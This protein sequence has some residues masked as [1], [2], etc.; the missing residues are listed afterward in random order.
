MDTYV[1][2]VGLQE[3]QDDLR[4]FTDSLKDVSDLWLK[5]VGPIRAGFKERMDSKGGTDRWPRWARSTVFNYSG[6]GM[7]GALLKSSGPGGQR[8]YNSLVS[9]G[10]DS[11]LNIGKTKMQIGTKREH[12]VE[13]NDGVDKRERGGFGP[14]KARM[15]RFYDKDW[16]GNDKPI[17]RRVVGGAPLLPGRTTKL[18]SRVMVAAVDHADRVLDIAADYFF[19]DTNPL[20][21][22]A[23]K[24]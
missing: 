17:F 12:A 18:R 16:S 11:V 22:N 24:I 3:F 15:L 7:R 21:R 1:R 13:L 10:S 2:V 6:K 5:C 23:T 14:V 9:G 8:L 19:G 4:E 20:F